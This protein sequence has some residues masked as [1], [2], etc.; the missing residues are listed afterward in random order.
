MELL[1]EHNRHTQ[2]IVGCLHDS[3]PDLVLIAL[4]DSGATHSCI[5]PSTIVELGLTHLIKPPE[6]PITEVELADSKTKVPRIGTLTLD[7]QIF[8]LGTDRATANLRMKLEI[9]T[10]HTDL[11]FGVDTLRTLFPND[12]L[13]RFFISPS[14]LASIPIPIDPLSPLDPSIEPTPITHTYLQNLRPLSQSSLPYHQRREQMVAAISVLDEMAAEQLCKLSK[15][16]EAVTTTSEED[17]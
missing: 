2:R 1:T 7:L 6:G 11:L 15:L 13:T 4:L 14:L 17:A 9:M 16:E 8:F 5:A 12:E 10:T 3:K